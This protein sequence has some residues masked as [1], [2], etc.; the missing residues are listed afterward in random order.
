MSTASVGSMRIQLQQQSG[1]RTIHYASQVLQAPGGVTTAELATA[2]RRLRTHA[3]IPAG[4]QSNAEAALARALK[5]V[6]ARP[7]AGVSGHF[8]KSFYFEPHQ[9]HASWRFDIEG[10]TGYNLRT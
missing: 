9:P 1:G 6:H 3:A 7:R 5:W 8:S 2:L 10:L 4:Q